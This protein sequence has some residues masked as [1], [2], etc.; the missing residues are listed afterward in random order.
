MSRG[1]AAWE[2]GDTRGFHVSRPKESFRRPLDVDASLAAGKRAVADASL[3]VERVDAHVA[4]CDAFIRRLRSKID[5]GADGGGKA[6]EQPAARDA[7]SPRILVLFIDGHADTRAV[8]SEYLALV[9]CEVDEADNGTDALAK[10]HARPHDLVVTEAALPGVDGYELC[11]QF[12]ND[13]ALR[14][15]PFIVITTDEQTSA[16]DRA[17]SAGADAVLVKPC[18]P[19]ALVAEIAR[20]VAD[21]VRAASAVDAGAPGEKRGPEEIDPRRI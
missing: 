3:H 19:T 13:A 15:T 2:R 5:H 10:A 7:A 12:R 6:G 1:A 11:R 18:L 16:A 21:D 17:R 8:Y 9:G 20:L 4:R 14:Q